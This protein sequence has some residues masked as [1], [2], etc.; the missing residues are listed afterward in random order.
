MTDKLWV[1]TNGFSKCGICGMDYQC[2]R[3]ELAKRADRIRELEFAM[4]MAAPLLKYNGPVLRVNADGFE[5]IWYECPFCHYQAWPGQLF[6]H[7]DAC[8]WPPFAV[9]LALLIEEAHD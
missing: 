1:E 4:K 2:I 6:I 7:S 8:P 5:N 9:A 3:T